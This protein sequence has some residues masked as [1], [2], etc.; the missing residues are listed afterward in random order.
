MG[1]R[2]ISIGIQF[3]RWRLIYSP[4]AWDEP[5]GTIN[6]HERRD[7]HS[8]ATDP[9]GDLI[10]GTCDT[11]QKEERPTITEYNIKISFIQVIHILFLLIKRVFSYLRVVN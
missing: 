5:R 10:L 2:E 6:F 8:G 9:L 1:F 7:I 3:L 11:R 4:T